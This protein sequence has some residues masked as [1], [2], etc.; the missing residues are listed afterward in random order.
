MSEAAFRVGKGVGSPRE[1]HLLGNDTPSSRGSARTHGSLELKGLSTVEE[2]GDRSEHGSVDEH[3]GAEPSRCNREASRPERED[4]SLVELAGVGGVGGLGER[5]AAAST[6]VPK[7]RELRDG[8]DRSADVHDGEVHA[9][10]LVLEDAQTGDLV[11]DVFDVRGAVI[12]AHAEVDEEPVVDASD[13]LVT[14]GDRGTSDP[15]YDGAH[16]V[17]W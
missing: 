1:R 3:R 12:S 2:D 5:G 6:D 4:E 17:W 7:E 9:T 16:R 13:Q 11:G 14:D 15:L 10:R 8:Q